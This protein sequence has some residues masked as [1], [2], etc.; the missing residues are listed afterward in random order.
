[1]DVLRR[2]AVSSIC[3]WWTRCGALSQALLLGVAGEADDLHEVA[4]A[5]WTVSRMLAVVMNITFERS[6]VTPR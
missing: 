4:R 5:G 1:V 3:F 2:D 6:K